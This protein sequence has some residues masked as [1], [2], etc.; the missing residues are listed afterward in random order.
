MTLRENIKRQFANLDPN[1]ITK[2]YADIEQFPYFAFR[3]SDYYGVAIPYTGEAVNE[4]FTSVNLIDNSSIDITDSKFEFDEYGNNYLL[5][6]CNN[7][8]LQNEFALI[9]SDFVYPDKNGNHRKEITKSPV[10]WWESWK[11]LLGNISVDYKPYCVI[12]ELITFNL[13]LEKGYNVKWAG[14]D[15]SSHDILGDNF[16]IEVKSSLRKYENIVH[17]AGEYQLNDN[18]KPLYLCFCKLESSNN[19]YSID[20]LVDLLVSKYNIS[21]IELNT[22]LKRIGYPE[23]NSSRR[24]NY[25]LLD[26]LLFKVDDEFP[27]ITKKNQDKWPSA[28]SKIEY[29]LNLTGLPCYPI[30]EF[31]ESRDE[32]AKALPT[33]S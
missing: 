2:R 31:G 8:E 12:A 6:R 3:T 29:E 13:L 21:R 7:L 24:Q 26:M 19:G 1:Q 23:G 10:E 30:F 25:V 32:I 11:G 28:F 4:K 5:L 18:G 15:S 16:D 9:C 22:K 20:S 27:K 14:P 17:I 33:R